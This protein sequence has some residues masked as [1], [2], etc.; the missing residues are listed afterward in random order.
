M[1]FIAYF[2]HVLRIGLYLG[3]VLT[4][5]FIATSVVCLPNDWHFATSLPEDFD[6]HYYR[7]QLSS[8]DSQKEKK[9]TGDIKYFE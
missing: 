4:L 7:H 2:E 3:T 9:P 5:Y 8:L 6:I 1:F